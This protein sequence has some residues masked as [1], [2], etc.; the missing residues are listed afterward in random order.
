MFL[1]APKICKRLLG[2]THQPARPGVETV[3]DTQPL[4]EYY[5]KPPKRLPWLAANCSPHFPARPPTDQRTGLFFGFA[6]AAVYQN[7]EFMLAPNICISRR[8]FGPLSTISSCFP[9]SA[10]DD[11]LAYLPACRLVSS[12]IR[13]LQGENLV[14]ENRNRGFLNPGGHKERDLKFLDQAGWSFEHFHPGFSL[15]MMKSWPEC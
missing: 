2:P 3:S 5:E 7:V 4:R 9:A 12:L 13:R 6:S 11:H 1:W 15:W 10:F 14:G 8:P